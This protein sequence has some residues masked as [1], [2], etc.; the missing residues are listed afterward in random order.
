VLL[1]CFWQC[2]SRP[3]SPQPA[4]LLLPQRPKPRVGCHLL[5]STWVFSPKIMQIL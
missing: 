3:P 5:G 1:F 2:Q 4:R